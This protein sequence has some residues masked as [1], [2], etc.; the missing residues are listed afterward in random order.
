[1][2]DEKLDYLLRFDPLDV[3]EQIT[4]TD[5][6]DLKSPAMALGF[7]L[8]VQNNARKQKML[9]ERGDTTF[10]NKLGRY[11]EIIEGAG[12]EKVLEEEFE[13]RY[14]RDTLFVYARRDG[15][16]LS[17]D[18]FR[19]E[20]SDEVSVNGG[21]LWYNWLPADVKNRWECTSSG[22]LREY[23][24]EKYLLWVGDH[25]CR[26]ALLHK[27]GCLEQNGEFLPRWVE[28]PSAFWIT[29]YMDWRSME[30]DR[31]DDRINR[32]KELSESRLAQMPEWVR[33]I[34]TPE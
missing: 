10:S 3:A 23:Q 29:H 2:S 16:I 21:K 17:F 5:T 12:F 34:V 14:A 13:G 20:G 18:T 4:G 27:I 1:M 19:W 31:F 6:H 26:E 15:L 9:I 24:G 32:I 8:M 7:A 22:G 33:E 30:N 28:R 11:Q 25:D